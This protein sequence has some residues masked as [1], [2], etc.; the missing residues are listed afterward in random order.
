[1]VT[2]FSL[3][4][5]KKLGDVILPVD[6]SLFPHGCWSASSQLVD[7]FTEIRHQPGH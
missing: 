1:M 6:F 3:V 2:A 4:V 7:T 5:K